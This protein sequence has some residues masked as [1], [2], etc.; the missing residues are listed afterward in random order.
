M[1]EAFA[2]TAWC[3]LALI[4]CVSALIQCVSISFKFNCMSR[5]MLSLRRYE[6]AHVYHYMNDQSV[7]RRGSSQHFF[8]PCHTYSVA[9]TSSAI[10]KGSPTNNATLFI[11]MTGV[12]N[13][14]SL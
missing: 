2:A 11:I 12:R 14:S 1:H 3:V 10:K 8:P 6:G 13:F 5:K 7:S 9:V 4:Q